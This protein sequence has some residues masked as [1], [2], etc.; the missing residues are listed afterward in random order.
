MSQD[1][2]TR[3]EPVP[4]APRMPAPR[5]GGL[6]AVLFLFLAA[7]AVVN[8]FREAPVEDDWAYAET[9]KHFLET[10]Q[11]RLNDWLSA[12]IA[13]QTA[14]GALFCLPAGFSFSALRVSTV[15]LAVI[16]LWARFGHWRWSIALDRG[17]ANL[18]TLVHRHVAALFQDEPD[19][20]VRRA[21]CRRDERGTAVV[22]PRP[23]AHDVAGVA[24]R[25]AG[26]RGVD[27]H[28][29]I[30]RRT[31]GGIGRRLACRP[32]AI[33]TTPP[34]CGRRGTARRGLR[35]GRSTGDGITPTGRRPTTSIASGTTSGG[36][37]FSR[38]CLGGRW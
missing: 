13:F 25:L 18:L 31:S 12:N 20:H 35:S 16:G 26:R 10:G 11:Y 21:F 6:I 37:A 27:P 29:P 32:A 7:T 38:T 22:H 2:P 1:K 36:R 33:R 17:T 30:W 23:L 28:P 8:P 15:V 24:G 19:V 4:P 34:L 3:D 9:V 14:W 5:G